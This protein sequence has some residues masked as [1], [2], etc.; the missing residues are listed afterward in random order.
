MRGPRYSCTHGRVLR[1]LED[2]NI[3][4]GKILF[5][6]TVVVSLSLTAILLQANKRPGYVCADC[7]VI[8]VSI[9]TLR[10]DHLGCYG[11]PLETTPHIDRFAEESVAAIKKQVFPVHHI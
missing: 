1:Y 2:P 3:S 9:D 8:V 10:A 5:A 7:N 4:H 6:L 11:Y